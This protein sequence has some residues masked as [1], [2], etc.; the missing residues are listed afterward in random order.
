MHSKQVNNQK[1]SKMK[2]TFKYIRLEDG[3][4]VKTIE[5]AEVVMQFNGGIQ[6]KGELF[7]Q[8]KCIASENIIEIVK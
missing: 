6:V 4:F 3:K 2:A 5:T 7:P 8:G 1:Y